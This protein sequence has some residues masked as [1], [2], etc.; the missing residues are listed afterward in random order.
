MPFD[1]RAFLKSTLAL[2][3]AM[4]GAA[5]DARAA[6]GELLYNGIRLGDPGPPRRRALD[7]YPVR[8]P[9]LD[10]PPP[11][12]SIDLGRQLFVDDFRIEETTL[13]RRC[14][15]ATY[16]D[17]NPVLRPTTAQER[18]D[19]VA[20]GTGARINPAA[21]RFTERRSDDH[22]A[23]R[24]SIRRAGNTTSSRSSTTSIA[25]RTR[26]CCSACSRSGVAKTRAARSRMTSA[27][28]SAATDFI[29]IEHRAR[30]F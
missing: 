16:L 9:Y 26:A 24:G 2:A 1:G 13:V 20:E 5:G 18:S 19:P 4:G 28:G 21:T 25:P 23:R 30:R 15:P 12:I 17:I 22:P 7:D 8:A 27:S 11:V 3:A 6:G 10:S 29:S 14:H